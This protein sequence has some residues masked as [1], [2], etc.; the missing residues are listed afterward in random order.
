M[1]ARAHAEGQDPSTASDPPPRG[2]MQIDRVF[3]PKNGR[4]TK[5]GGGDLDSVRGG[6][7]DSI[8]IN[9]HTQTRKKVLSFG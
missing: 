7:A 2:I 8:Q 1:K 3:G 5:K 4:G 6:G 9:L